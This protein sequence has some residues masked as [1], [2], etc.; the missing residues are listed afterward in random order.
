[1]ELISFTV[2]TQ[3]I[4]VFV[5]AHAD[6]CSGSYHKTRMHSLHDSERLSFLYHSYFGQNPVVPYDTSTSGM[7]NKLWITSSIS[8]GGTV[9]P[10]NAV[11]IGNR[12]YALGFKYHPSK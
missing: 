2:S 10:T 12:E 11:D 8:I 6:W 7:G 5:F 3:L 1:M 9:T 4:C